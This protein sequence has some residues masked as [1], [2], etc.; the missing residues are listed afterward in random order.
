MNQIGSKWIK[1]DQNES[2]ASNSINGS[3]NTNEDKKNKKDQKDEKIFFKKWIKKDQTWLSKTSYCTFCGE[4]FQL[5]SRPHS[6]TAK[7]SGLHNKS[8]KM[9]KVSWSSSKDEI[10]A[11][12]I[13]LDQIGL[14]WIKMNKIGS[15]WNKL[16][17]TASNSSNGSNSINKIKRTKKDFF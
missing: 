7:T 3:N 4:K 5:K 12:W 1:L 2:T 11:N 10:N 8:L 9:D 6:P 17:Q 15:K 14:K 13:K 16:D